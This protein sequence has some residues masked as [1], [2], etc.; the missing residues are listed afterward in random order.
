VKAAGWFL[1]G[2][3]IALF[4]LD[5]WDLLRVSEWVSGTFL[6]AGAA[7]WLWGGKEEEDRENEERE[8]RMEHEDRIREESARA[9]RERAER[10]RD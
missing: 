5:E 9:E 1:F 8:R 2:V 10:E 3:A 7:L 6:V 4:F